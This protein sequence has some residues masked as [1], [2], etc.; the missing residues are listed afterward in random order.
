MRQPVLYIYTVLTYAVLY[1]FTIFNTLLVLTL[2]RLGLQKAIRRVL[3]FWAKG[4]FIIL[5]KHFKIEGRENINKERKYILIANHSSLFD[6][7]G[8]MTLCPGLSWFG[9]A[10]LLNIPVFGKLLKVINYIP[11]KSSDLKNVKQMIDQLVENT[12]NRTVAIFPEGTRTINGELST[13]HKGFLHVLKASKLDILPV[14]LIGFYA[15][16]PKNRFY[17]DYSIKLFAKIHP[18]IPYNELEKLEDKEIIHKVKSI[19]EAA[20]S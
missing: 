12:K 4:T 19:I 16:K 14:S 15:F 3:G 18:P 6:I 11:M 8:I 5:G 17:F 7:M 20:I 1:P 2:N 13:F 10:H 9:R